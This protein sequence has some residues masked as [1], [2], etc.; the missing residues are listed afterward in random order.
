MKKQI[1]AGAAMII[2]IAGAAFA[3]TIDVWGQMFEVEDAR[4]MTVDVGILTDVKTRRHHMNYIKLKNGHMMAVVPMDQ[5]MAL[6]KPTGPD[7]MLQ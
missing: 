6:G 5:Y 1:V 2:L 3:R 7:D 4:P